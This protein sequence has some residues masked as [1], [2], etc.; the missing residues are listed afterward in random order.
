M[1]TWRATARAFNVTGD[2]INR[3]LRALSVG[4]VAGDMPQRPLVDG[5]E[6]MSP[7]E[8]F[9]FFRCRA[10]MRHANGYRDRGHCTGHEAAWGDS[11]GAGVADEGCLASADHSR[12]EE[13]RVETECVS[14]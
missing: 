1:G 7:L 10:T 6:R 11:R 14:T 13:R 9:P 2:A 5:S 3:M 12:S 8:G 4:H